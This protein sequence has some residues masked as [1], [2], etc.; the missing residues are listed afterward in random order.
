MQP[1]PYGAT[2]EDAVKDAH[3]R[4]E[5]LRVP[6]PSRNELWRCPKAV[7]DREL[8]TELRNAG[9]VALASRLR[10]AL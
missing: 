10:L 7:G 8:P 4:L 2:A 9:Q 1:R 6:T 3:A 5:G